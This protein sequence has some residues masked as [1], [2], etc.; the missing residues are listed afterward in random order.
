MKKGKKNKRPPPLSP[1]KYKNGGRGERERERERE[2]TTAC[3]PLPPTHQPTHSTN[4]TP[5]HPTHTPPPPPKSN[6]NNTVAVLAPN[7][8]VVEN[9]NTLYAISQMFSISVDDLKR[10]NN[11]KTTVISVGQKLIIK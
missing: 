2:Q 5:T 3:P 4:N 8:Y 10:L 11:L 9:G 1:K 6:I 7:E